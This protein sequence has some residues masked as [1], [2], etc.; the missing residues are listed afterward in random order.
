MDL[1]DCSY[2]YV[3]PLQI[4]NARRLD[5][6]D[7]NAAAVQETIEAYI[8]RYQG[9]YLLK[10]VGG[11]VASEVVAYLDGGGNDDRA[12]ELCEQLRLSFAHYV[13]FKLIGDVNQQATIT[14]LVKIKTANDTQP[15]RQRMVRVWNDMVEL[16]KRFV[17]WAATSHYEVR[18]QVEM[19]TPINQYNL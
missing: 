8:H 11:G 4:E 16:N 12:E 10:M 13:Y 18:Y 7:N 15:P 19:I 14:G 5:D 9:E 2:F 17:A 6:L 3:G 1:I